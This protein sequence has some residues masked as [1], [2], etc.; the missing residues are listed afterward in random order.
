MAKQRQANNSVS[1]HTNATRQCHLPSSHR[2]GKLLP[3]RKK[4]ITDHLHRNR[5]VPHQ[6][7]KTK[8]GREVTDAPQV[9]WSAAADKPDVSGG[10]ILR[11]FVYFDRCSC[12]WRREKPRSVC[13]HWVNC[14]FEQGNPGARKGLNVALSEKKNKVK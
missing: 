8:R 5:G 10:A 4:R 11:V 12:G 3:K 2:T 6:M 7:G 14:L 9:L 1:C 13:G